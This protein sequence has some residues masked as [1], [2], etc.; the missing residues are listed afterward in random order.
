M[1]FVL[2]NTLTACKE[3][4]VPTEGGRL[5][6]YSCGPTV[7]RPVHVGNLRSFLLADFIARVA[8]YHGL[9]VF[10]VM[11]ITDVGHMTDE[12][13]DEGRDK[14]LL[15]AEDEGLSTAQIAERYTNAFFAD[16]DAV[17]IRRAKLYPK[18]SD[19]IPQIID[20]V[21]TLVERGHAY[22]VAGNVY[23]DVTTFAGY[24]RLSHQALDDMRAGHRHDGVDTRKRNHQDFA[25]W[26]AA[27]PRR[28]LVFESP[29]GRGYPGWH[30]ECSAMSLHHLGERF[31]VHTAGVD[32]RFPHHEDEIAQSEG[33]VGHQVVRMWVHGEHLLLGEAKMAKSAGNVLTISDIVA[34]GIDPIA[35]RYLCFTA[36]YR[37]QFHFSED[38]LL[39]AATALRRLRET[40][41]AF[42]GDGA[43]CRTDAELRATLSDPAAVSYHDRFMQAVGEDLDFPQALKVVHELVADGDVPTETRRAVIVSWD[44][45][46]GLNL[47]AETDLPDEVR[48]LID[49]R[50]AARANGDYARSD[51]IREELHRRGVDVLDSPSGT[52]WVRR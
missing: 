22:V 12:L 39:A 1:D 5:T 41:A 23:Y 4:V 38:A 52:R 3:K 13:T 31:D 36:K 47:V 18:A 49:E 20:L 10:N 42:P 14:M 21:S 7:Y 51:Q 45:I 40:V 28:E 25:L 30:I 48:A 37:R 26:V 24:G 46:L 44:E 15:A 34:R 50:N 19:H 29:W 9:D 2:Y 33:A 11:N 6:M 43:V 16:I 35:Y 32:L 27:G 8:A 17:N